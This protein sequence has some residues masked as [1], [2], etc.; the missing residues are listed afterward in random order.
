MKAEEKINRERGFALG[1]CFFWF[2]LI[3]YVGH[4]DFAGSL[5]DKCCFAFCLGVAWCLSVWGSR[6]NWDGFTV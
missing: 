1:S 6:R 4:S 2:S 3:M 5:V